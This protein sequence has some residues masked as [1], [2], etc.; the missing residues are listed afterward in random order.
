MYAENREGLEIGR[1]P[2]TAA[3]ISSGDGEDDRRP[4]WVPRDH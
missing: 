3:G 1:D 2:G 4:W